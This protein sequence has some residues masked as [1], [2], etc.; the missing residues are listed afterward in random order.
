MPTS[1]FLRRRSENGFK[2]E[3]PTPISFISTECL[4]NIEHTQNIHIVH[5]RNGAE[6]RVG[7]KQIPVDG[8]CKYVN[9]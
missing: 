7:E 4:A 8:Y 6:Y 2:K 3:Y 9:L 5:A 1:M